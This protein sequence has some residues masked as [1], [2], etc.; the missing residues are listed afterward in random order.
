MLMNH[1]P[2]SWGK[3][4]PVSTSSNAAH[5][6]ACAEI[7][8]NAH[9]HGITS[10]ADS[11][12]FSRTQDPI[13]TGTSV[14]GIMYK[15]GVMLATDCLLSY[16]SLARF[17]EI[18]RLA[19]VNQNTVIGSSGE[20]SDFQFTIKML[21]DVMINEYCMNDGHALT[22]EQVHAVLATVMYQRRSKFDP[23]WNAH[24]VAGFREGDRFLGYVD[25]LGT[26]YKSASI[27]TGFGAYLA[28][29]I[30]R[31]AVE[32]GG[33]NNLAEADAKKILEDCMRVLFY[34]DARSLNKIQIAVVNEKG[35][36]ISAPYALQTNWEFANMICGY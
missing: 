35:C 2:A 14:L 30:L 21:N 34:R 18:S 27:A 12:P 36:E 11:M 20:Y 29:P 9:T 22:P 32:A 25:L 5:D 28:Q 26:T 19:S 1:F 17:R 33:E 4:K 16:G 13:V 15:D 31:K 8:N 3:Y 10:R 23:L 7:F 6:D 24:V